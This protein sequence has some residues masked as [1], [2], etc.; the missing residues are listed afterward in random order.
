VHSANFIREADF[1][2]SRVLEASGGML[3][4]LRVENTE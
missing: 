4:F 3:G 1:A 2:V